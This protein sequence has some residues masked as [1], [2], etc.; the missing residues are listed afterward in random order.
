MM[1]GKRISRGSRAVC[2][3]IGTGGESDCTNDGNKDSYFHIALPIRAANQSRRLTLSITCAG[4][5][6][7]ELQNLILTF[8]NAL[9]NR[10]T[11][12]PPR[13]VDA[14]VMRNF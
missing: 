9:D 12:E 2:R 3:F 1:G 10:F 11:P 7:T 4:L 5:E 14:I 13:Q 8:K 6:C